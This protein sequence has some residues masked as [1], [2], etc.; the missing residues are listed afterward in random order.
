M[1]TS[2]FAT[3][4][5]FAKGPVKGFNLILNNFVRLTLHNFYLGNVPKYRYL[6]VISDLRLNWSEHCKILRQKS[7][8]L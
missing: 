3:M 8:V 1:K 5:R 4:A 2:I 6:E 7:I